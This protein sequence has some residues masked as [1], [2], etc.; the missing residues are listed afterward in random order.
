M[1]VLRSSIA[2]ALVLCSSMALAAKHGPRGEL[3]YRGMADASA[4]IPIGEHMFVVADDEH[5]SLRVYRRD[6]GGFPIQSFNLNS[7]L[8]RSDKEEEADLEGAAQIG[9]TVYWIGSHGRNKNGKRQPAREVIFGTEVLLVENKVRMRAVGRPYHQLLDDLVVSPDLSK[10]N[11]RD[12]SWLAP[13]A[14]GGLNIEG[15]AAA[16]DGKLLIGFRNPI[17]DG[18]ALLVPLLNPAEM[19]S[20][21]RA[22][23]GKPIELDLEGLGI[24]DIVYMPPAKQYI[25]LAGPYASGKSRIYTWSGVPSD[26]PVPISGVDLAGWN[27]EACLIYPNESA[28]VQILS[29]DGAAKDATTKEATLATFRGGWVRLP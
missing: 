23:L 15:L 13:K 14:K 8:T 19:L 16:P 25:V 21:R 1:L 2:L 17:R 6:R 22:R 29:D 4:A 12:A 10:Y 24:R 3:V 9:K 20:G 18:Q 5:N 11:L 7:L 26:S 28:Q 27:P